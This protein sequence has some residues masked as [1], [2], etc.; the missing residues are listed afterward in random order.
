MI[1]GGIRYLENGEFRLVKEAAQER[2]LLLENA[3]HYVKPLS[4]VIPIY[5]WFSGLFNAPMK[6]L[7]LGDKPSERGAVVIKIGLILYDLYSV[8][9]AEFPKHK[10]N[11][12]SASLNEFPQINPEII[13]T[14]QY[15]DA[16][17]LS[18]ERICIEMVLDSESANLNAHGLN[19]ASV[20]GASGDTVKLKDRLSGQVISVQP[21]IVINA[22]GP[23]IDLVND[24]IGIKTKFIGG[25]K[26][27][28]LILN[29]QDLR[30]AIGEN[31]IFFENKDGRIVLI[32]PMGN[33]VMVGSTDIPIEDP[34]NAFC[35]DDEIE[36]F[37][38]MVKFIFPGISINRDQIIFQFSGVRPLP[39]SDTRQTGQIS[40]DHSIREV[41]DRNGIKFPILNLVGG[42]WTT[43]R[44]F[45]EQVT[46]QTLA[47]LG[48][49]RKVN[50]HKLKI[51]GGQD[52]PKNPSTVKRWI[53]THAKN[54]GLSDETVENLFNRYGTRASKVIEHSLGVEDTHLGQ[55]PHYYEFEIQCITKEE[56]VVHLDD[57]LLRRSSLAK[58]GELT[59]E[60]IA[61]FADII[62]KELSWS[63]S[64]IA[65]EIQRVYEILGRY[66]GVNI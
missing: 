43:F 65:E 35:T 54:S 57:Y 29:N 31:E 41:R 22:A 3:P 14:A 42:K 20:Q 11:S 2:N 58:M 62:S 8:R 61:E 7:G 45:S 63:N 49:V 1:H 36:Y 51:G 53:D 15:Y 9:Q 30:I 37:I 10:L 19:Y 52:Y 55:F 21:E 66:H 4:T 56:K 23:W 27:S 25:T 16:A 26:G 6:F 40:R 60:G 38:D 48:K 33:T 17:M 24:R 34:D 50:T 59:E 32:N 12:R 44:S 46:D 13:F 18:P 39:A 64:Q 47:S 5:K 28:H